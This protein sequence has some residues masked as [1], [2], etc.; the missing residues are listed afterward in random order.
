MLKI[1]VKGKFTG[2]TGKSCVVQKRLEE[3]DFG[4]YKPNL[5]MLANKAGDWY[6]IQ[7]PWWQEYEGK[8]IFLMENF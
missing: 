6:V 4:I 2:L 1:Y 5:A 3:W 7:T 8:N